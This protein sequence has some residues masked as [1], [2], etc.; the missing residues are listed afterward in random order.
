MGLDCQV[1]LQHGDNPSERGG[2]GTSIQ[3]KPVLAQRAKTQ[4]L[5]MGA[6]MSLQVLG[7]VTHHTNVFHPKKTEIFKLLNLQ[8]LGERS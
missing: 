3:L 5:A 6:N 2:G 4:I 8:E 7:M 1:Q